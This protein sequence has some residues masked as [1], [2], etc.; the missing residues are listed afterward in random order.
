[1]ANG[2][3]FNG[4]S[5]LAVEHLKYLYMSPQGRIN[6]QRIWLG[7]LLLSLAV[8]AL[9]AAALILASIGS[10]L[11][12]IAII[13]YIAALIFP[14]IAEIMLFIKRAHDRN[15]S[16]WYILLTMIP[17]VGIIWTIELLFFKGTE[18]ANQYG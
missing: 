3:D 12:V 7:A 10:F 18:G 16:G 6:R 2:G 15:H 1:M 4:I 14:N 13:I 8:I 11:T 9:F 5:F 17:I